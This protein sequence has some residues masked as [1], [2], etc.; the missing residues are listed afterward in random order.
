MSVPIDL[1]VGI[2]PS[3]SNLSQSGGPFVNNSE[4]VFGNGIFG[5]QYQDQ[6]AQANPTASASG[7]GSA[8]ANPYAPNGSLVS[9]AG[10]SSSLLLYGAIA[11]AGGLALWYFLRKGKKT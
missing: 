9:S 3:A 10:G 6:S 11:V 7:K 1:G 5:A 2:A 4:I 8:V